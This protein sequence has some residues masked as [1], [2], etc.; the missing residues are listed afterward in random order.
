[1]LVQGGFDD[2]GDVGKGYLAVQKVINSHF[3]RRAQDCWIR[4]SAS[5]RL[6]RQKGAAK[7]FSVHRIKAQLAQLYEIQWWDWIR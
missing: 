7:P 5:A 3:V 1:M 2:I 6:E 4:P